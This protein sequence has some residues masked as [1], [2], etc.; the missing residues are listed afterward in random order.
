MFFICFLL[1]MHTMIIHYFS[2]RSLF[3][4]PDITAIQSPEVPTAHSGIEG[5]RQGFEQA[6]TLIRRHTKNARANYHSHPRV[7]L[8]S[9]MLHCL[10]VAY[11]CNS[12]RFWSFTRNP[13]S[14]RTSSIISKVFS[15]SAVTL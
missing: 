11:P 15:L 9:L 2:Y 5:G 8:F 14:F 10:T 4:Y 6:R 1:Y 12:S 7:H 3:D 13:F